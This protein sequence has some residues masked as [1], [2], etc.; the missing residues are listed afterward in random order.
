[1][2]RRNSVLDRLTFGDRVPWGV[3][4]LLAVTIVVSLTA[5][6]GSRHVLPLFDLGALVAARVFQGE[7]WRLVTWAVMEPSP[8]SLIF[9]CLFLYWFGRDLA[10]AWGSRR[11]LAVYFGVGLVAAIGTCVIAVWDKAVRPYPY[12][13]SWPLVEAM[14]VAWGLWFPDRIIRIYFVI[15]IRG[16]VLAWLTVALTV[17][18]AIYAGWDH[19][20]PNL[21]AE[22]SILAWLYRAPVVSRWKN[23]RKA[24][25]AAARKA[26]TRAKQEQR[27]ATVHVLRTI[28][29]Q[30]D[31]PAPLTPEAE[32]KLV[33]LFGDA[34][35]KK[36]DSEKD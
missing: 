7:L 26:R 13:G 15:P 18:Y 25:E 17:V 24:R 33:Q 36:R 16:Y 4:L 11:F 34:S 30:D 19:F 29:A 28:E 6:L 20:L 22:G 9:G 31:D 12:V 1:M 3:G 2:A 27:M 21:L 32:G 8:I 5:A 23:W 10:G 14:T 35:K